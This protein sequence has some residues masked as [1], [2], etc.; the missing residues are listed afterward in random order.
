MHDHLFDF[1]Q[2]PIPCAE[3]HLPDEVDESAEPPHEF[4]IKPVPFE[5]QFT[6]KESCLRCHEGEDEAWVDEK[7]PTLR[8]QL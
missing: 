5:E 8:F 6:V 7:L 2:P 3:C 4:N 1:S